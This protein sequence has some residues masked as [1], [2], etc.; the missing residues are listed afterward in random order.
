MVV[1]DVVLWFFGGM[2]MAVVCGRRSG[3]IALTGGVAVVALV[4]V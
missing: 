3:S 4:V 2:I 1:M